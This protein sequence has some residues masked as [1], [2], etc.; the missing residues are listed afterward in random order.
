MPKA[1]LNGI[2]G[3]DGSYLFGTNVSSADGRRGEALT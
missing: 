3:Q 2:T 1:F